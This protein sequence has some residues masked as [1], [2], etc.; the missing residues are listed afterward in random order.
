MQH[1]RVGPLSVVAVDDLA[2]QPQIRVEL[3]SEGAQITQE[4]KTKRVCSVQADAVDLKLLLPHA[5]GIKKVLFCCRL[6]QVELDQVEVP[7]PGSVA[8]GVA[9]GRAL[10]ETQAGKPVLV[11]GVLTIGLQVSESPEVAPNMVEDAIE[12]ELH[13]AS[14]Q[15]P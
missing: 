3:V 5:D 6:S 12:H 13:A 7:V 9:M 1:A 14:M 4:I 15:L 8:E 11:R 2:H 10:V